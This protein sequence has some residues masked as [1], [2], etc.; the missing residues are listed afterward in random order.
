[1]GFAFS[2]GSARL[3]PNLLRAT[4]ANADRQKGLNRTGYTFAR[5]LVFPVVRTS[6]MP[7]KEASIGVFGIGLAAYWPQFSG[8]KE[9]LE[10]YQQKVEQR[11]AEWAAV[12]SGGLVDDA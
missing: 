12:T 6:T 5:E 2:P 1:M 4:W 7:Q 9:R 3:R 10:G 11:I 8:L